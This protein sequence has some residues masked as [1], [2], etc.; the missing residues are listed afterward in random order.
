MLIL[1]DYVRAQAEWREGKAEQYP[2]DE[3]NHRSAES[4][5]ALA[6][7][8]EELRAEDG[9][10]IGAIEELIRRQRWGSPGKGVEQAVSRYGFDREPPAAREFLEEL[11]AAAR[12]D[13]ARARAFDHLLPRITAQA[14]DAARLWE[15]NRAV[16]G[17]RRA[18][19]ARAVSERLARRGGLQ[20]ELEGVRVVAELSVR[21][22]RADGS[23]ATVEVDLSEH[24]ELEEEI[25]GLLGGSSLDGASIVIS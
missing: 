17:P 8:L 18:A 5:R 24:F 10:L 21:E 16:L 19:R 14:A 2:E 25:R 23:L 7:T 11:L 9:E 6:G 15:S 3:R 13:A 1:A 12:E 4:L 22:P 20:V